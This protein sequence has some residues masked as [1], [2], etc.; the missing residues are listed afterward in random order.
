MHNRED[1]EDVAQD[2]FIQVY[3]SMHHFR[4]ESEIPTWIYRIAV[5]KSF[6]FIRRK[7]RK[8]RFARLVSI[9]SGGESESVDP[10][11]QLNPHGELEDRE[12]QQIL[13]QAVDKLP[14]KQAE[15]ERL[16]FRH[17][18]EFKQLCRPEQR[19]KLKILMHEM[20]RGRVG[21]PPPRDK[22]R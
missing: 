17:F 14:E 11:A 4:E 22:Y 6:D 1:A 3:E 13:K 15:I 21:H 10:P 8:K 16:T 19:D 18:I 5:N 12:R 20:F 9:V 2:V 7:K